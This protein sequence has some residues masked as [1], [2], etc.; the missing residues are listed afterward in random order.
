[1]K[2][3]AM[4]VIAFVPSTAG[5]RAPVAALPVKT[6]S[7]N[8]VNL[9]YVEQGKGVPVVFVHGAISDHR[10]WDLQRDPVARR[11]RFVAVDQRYFGSGSWVDDGSKFSPA[12]HVADLVAFVRTLGTGPVYLVGRS[13]GAGIALAAAVEHPELVRGL[14]LNEPPLPSLVSDPAEQAI[15]TEERK[16]LADVNATVKAGDAAGATRLFFDW[17]NSQPGTFAAAAPSTRSMHLDNA[18]TLPL[19]LASP[20]NKLA[21]DQLGALAIPV[22]ITRGEL[23]RPYFRITAESAHRCLPRSQLI[24]IPGARHGAPSQQPAAFNEALLAFLARH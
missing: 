24:V 8:G 22:V 20:P 19:Q 12:T 2:W 23:T 16:G 15:L 11:H 10:A 3:L 13:Y 17:V 9:T 4:L 6:A 7:A 1:M 18:R 21:C 14:F 5:A